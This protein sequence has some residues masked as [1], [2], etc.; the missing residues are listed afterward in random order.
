MDHP[1]QR[2]LLRVENG[3]A[4]FFIEIIQRIKAEFK[5]LAFFELAT[6]EIDFFRGIPIGLGNHIVRHGVEDPQQLWRVSLPHMDAQ[7][8]HNDLPVAGGLVDNFQSVPDFQQL[9]KQPV[10]ALN[11]PLLVFIQK[12]NVFVNGLVVF[13]KI[14]QPG[15]TFNE[16]M[17]PVVH[18][19]PAVNHL[20]VPVFRIFYGIAALHPSGNGGKRHIVPVFVHHAALAEEQ[21]KAPAQGENCGAASLPEGGIL[22]D[23]HGVIVP[24][25]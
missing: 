3:V 15:H 25:F 24:F 18:Q 5:G 16:E 19:I 12:E 4:V 6:A 23:L 11:F 8:R 9:Q 2:H 13:Q 7:L 10:V 22:P 14:P 21:T 17:A 1:I 20:F